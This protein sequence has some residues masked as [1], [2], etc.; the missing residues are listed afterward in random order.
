VVGNSSAEIDAPL[1]KVWELVEKVE[2]APQWQGGMKDVEALERDRQGRAIRCEVAADIKVRTVK[3]IVRFDYDGGPNRLSWSQEKGD[4]QSVDGSWEL[5]DLGDGRT[6]ATY[7]IDADLGR[8][9]GAV[10]R[11]PLEGA[12]R[13]LLAGARADELKQRVE[14]GG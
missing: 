3:T 9:L 2:L 12:L 8:M 4:L 5:E 1:E 7:T 6:R 10:V 14:S 13:D 11:G